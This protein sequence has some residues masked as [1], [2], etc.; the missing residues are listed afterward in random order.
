MIVLSTADSVEISYSLMAALLA[1]AIFSTFPK[2][3]QKTHPTLQDFNFSNFF[4]HL[5]Q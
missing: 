5:D 1:N 3:T 2:R 4:K